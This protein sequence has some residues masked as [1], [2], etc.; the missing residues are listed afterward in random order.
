MKPA[1]ID[2]DG[3]I[4]D[5]VRAM[6]PLLGMPG[7][8]EP[9]SW[10]WKPDVSDEYFAKGWEKLKATENFWVTVSVYVDNLKALRKH[11]GDVLFVTSRVQSAGASVFEQTHRWLNTL[12]LPFYWSVVVVDGARQKGLIARATGAIASIDD[13]PPNVR[14]LAA[15]PGHAAYLL[16]R[17]WNKSAR[18]L[19]AH[20]VLDM[21]EF[22]QSHRFLVSS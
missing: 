6:N 12:R 1:I 21:A 20:R 8:Y 11:K 18:D 4:A 9:T 14:K 5:F 10:G 15:I 2:V 19:D 7:D 3:V 17:P 16:N 13:Y 22:L